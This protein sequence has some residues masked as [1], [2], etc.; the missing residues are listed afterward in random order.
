MERE[1]KFLEENIELPKPMCIIRGYVQKSGR[2]LSF[3]YRNRYLELNPY[4]GLLY[5]YKTIEDYKKKNPNEIIKILSISNCEIKNE[6]FKFDYN[7]KQEMYKTNSKKCSETWVYYIKESI[8]F[9]SF[10]KKLNKNYKNVEEYLQNEYKSITTY[11]IIDITTG[12][13]TIYDKNTNKEI[14][15]P[16]SIWNNSELKKEFNND[17]NDNNMNKSIIEYYE[18]NFLGFKNY[19]IVDMIGKSFFGKVFKVMYKRDKKIYAMKVLNKDKIIKKNFLKNIKYELEI[20][21]ENKNKFL[22]N[23]CQTFQTPNYLYFI[24]EYCEGNDLDFYIENKKLFNEDEIKFIM[25]ELI[26]AIDFLHKN[27]VIIKDLKPE[28]ILVDSEGHFKI[29]IFSLNKYLDMKSIE[30][31]NNNNNN[32]SNNIIN[33]ISNG[34]INNDINSINGTLIYFAPEILNKKE[35]TFKADI[36]CL[37]CIIYELFTGNNLYNNIKKEKIIEE[38]LNKD[39]INKQIDL[40]SEK[41]SE[42]L[43]NLLKKMLEKDVEKRFNLEDIKSHEFFVDVKWEEI[44]EKKNKII[45]N[46]N[47]YRKKNLEKEKNEFNKINEI[48]FDDNDYTENNKNIQRIRKFTYIEGEENEEKDF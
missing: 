26:E 10:Y 36:Y 18:K 42:N 22:V 6:F 3:K 7:D 30:N 32:N 46:L 19:L 39:F 20:L 41:I 31:E 14:N 28:N 24:F 29:N 11:I 48:E 23:L 34:N 4:K 17:I 27:G 2:K 15:N 47:E 25:S 37:G 5:R 45:I 43:K 38:I 9:Y 33:M 16:N 12:K 21:K 44:K 13:D 35:P 8:S 40:L 1:Y